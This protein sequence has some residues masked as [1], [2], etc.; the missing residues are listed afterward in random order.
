[1]LRGGVFCLV[2]ML[3]GAACLLGLAGC[4]AVK[5]VQADGTED[6]SVR[7]L[8]SEIVSRP[9]HSPQLITVTAFGL[10]NTANGFDLGFRTEDIVVAPAKCHAIFVVRS[11]AQAETAGK[12]AGVV[13]Q[14]C[15][16][17]R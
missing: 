3:I 11:G 14:S 10:S 4:A 15:I 2:R 8:H 16:V 9:T 12:L 1:V 17:Q 13:D 6:L 7:P 5:I